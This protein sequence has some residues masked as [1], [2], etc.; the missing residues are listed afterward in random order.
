MM[1][2]S[3]CHLDMLDNLDEVMERAR[4][5]GVE[6][7]I[8]PSVNYNSAIK[9][10]EIAN[11]YEN[12]W[13]GLGIHPEEVENNK[14]IEEDVIKIESLI[15]QKNKKVVAIG[16]CGLDFGKDT[17]EDI[18]QK[19][20]QLFKA[21]LEWAVKYNLPIIIHNRRAGEEIIE[22]LKQVKNDYWMKNKIKKEI[23]GV[24]HC[25]SGGKKLV[26]KILESLNFYFGVTGIVT[27]DEGL[28]NVLREVPI[29]RMLIETDAPYLIPMPIKK[30]REF[31]N[32]PANVSYVAEKIAE[33]KEIKIEE[34][35]EITSKNCV[36]LFN[37]VDNI[38]K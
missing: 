38:A 6:K 35:A 11:K 18:K 9:C 3:H 5:K 2:D 24:F 33:I 21:H 27:F 1:I 19:Q 14:N 4:L 17:S 7:I 30:E 37:I 13:V 28:S 16:E 26:K 32:E 20:I 29:E 8:L 36:D 25:Y 22:I 31:P 10:L 12:V 15:C 34:V 23:G